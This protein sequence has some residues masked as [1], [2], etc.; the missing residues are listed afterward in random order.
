M[1]RLQN[2]LNDQILNKYESPLMHCIKRFPFS[3]ILSRKQENFYQ[4]ITNN[5]CIQG[6]LVESDLKRPY[7]RSERN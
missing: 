4:C 3:N 6:V 2:E 1:N 5:I 7:F